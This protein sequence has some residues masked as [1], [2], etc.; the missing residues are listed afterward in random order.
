MEISAAENRIYQLETDV[1]SLVD[2]NDKLKKELRE[3]TEQL[4][5]K[6]DESNNRFELLSKTIDDCLKYRNE[7]K[8]LEEVLDMIKK[9][10]D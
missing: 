10:L 9:I 4:K 6:E 1:D 5:K 3:T 8:E 2:Q 7:I